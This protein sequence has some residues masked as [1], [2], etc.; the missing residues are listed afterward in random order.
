MNT[1][2][3]ALTMARKTAIRAILHRENKKIQSIPVD[4]VT[5]NTLGGG[6]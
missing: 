2:R 5:K 4:A 3:K 1:K 6:D